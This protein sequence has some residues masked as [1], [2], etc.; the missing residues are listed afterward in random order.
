MAIKLIENPNKSERRC[1][2]SDKR[3]IDYEI[4]APKDSIKINIL[5]KIIMVINLSL[6]IF[7]I[8]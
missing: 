1:T 8:N 5:T 6:T 7:F 3:A 4:Y 2:T